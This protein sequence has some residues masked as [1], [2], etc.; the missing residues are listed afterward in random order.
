MNENEIRDV[1]RRTVS[2]LDEAGVPEDLRVPAFVKAWEELSGTAPETA[3]GPRV[4]DEG[5]AEPG[6]HGGSGVSALAKKLG[7]EPQ[8]AGEA[9]EETEG[10]PFRVVVPTR[11]LPKEKSSATQDLAL[12]VCAGQQFDSNVAT[13]ASDIREICN[14]YGKFDSANFAGIMTSRDDL[15]IVSGKGANRTFKLRRGAWEKAGEV[16][17]RLIGE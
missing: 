9:F 1:L 5:T 6:G 17:R 7:V 14:E 8:H 11:N 2:L 13:P 15:W 12:L 3:L 10:G 4:R 16:V